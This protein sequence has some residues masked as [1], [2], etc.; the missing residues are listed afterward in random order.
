MVFLPILLFHLVVDSTLTLSAASPCIS[1]DF[2]SDA[3]KTIEEEPK[4]EGA[5]SYLQRRATTIGHKSKVISQF[6]HQATTNVKSEEAK[7]VSK[8]TALQVLT[9]IRTT[10]VAIYLGT[11]SLSGLVIACIYWPLG[12]AITFKILAYLSM[13][14]FIALSVKLVFTDSFAFHFPR[15]LTTFHLFVSAALGFSIL[16]HR[17]YFQGKPIQYPTLSEFTYKLLPLCL[18]FSYSLGCANA[19]LVYCSVAFTAIIGAS[20][21]FFSILLIVLLGMPFEWYL[22][23]PV[24]GIVFGCMATVM[25]TLEFSMYGFILIL[26][27]NI[28][29]AA[30]AVL[31]QWVMTG[32]VKEKYDPV[33]L[34]AWQCLICTP[35]MLAWSIF[36]EGTPAFAALFR[37]DQP[38]LFFGIVSVSCAIAAGQNALHIFVIKDLG[39]IGIQTTAQLRQGL[40]VL[41]GVLLFGEAFTPLNLAGGVIVLLSAFWYTRADARL[42]REAKERQESSQSLTC[43]DAQTV[44]EVKNVLQDSI[45]QLKLK[46]DNEERVPSKA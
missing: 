5:I 18:G 20:T 38:F 44:R 39:A 43:N 16:L 28:G 36:S 1:D 25:G 42:K 30:K 8:K 19:A 29:R 34:L 46:N 21:P 37:Q 17:S 12:P 14:C 3:C 41:G 15:L 10:E 13:G 22:L 6:Q 4:D 26:L 23:L 9:S 40:T 24:S 45:S 7:G 35:M 32:E 33:T 2:T 11:L 27:A 31:Q